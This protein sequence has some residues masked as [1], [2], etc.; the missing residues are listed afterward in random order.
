MLQQPP[1]GSMSSTGVELAPVGC[2]ESTR[3]GA[4]RQICHAW[5][6]AAATAVLHSSKGAELVPAIYADSTREAH[7]DRYAIRAPHSRRV[8]ARDTDL[9]VLV[10]RSS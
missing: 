8:R 2:A 7:G 3:D 6:V 1:A 4:V 10:R 5:D 9:P